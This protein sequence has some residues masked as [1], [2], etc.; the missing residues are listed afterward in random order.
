M[1]AAVDRAALGRANRRKG[2]DAERAVAKWLRANGFPHAER[3]VRTGYT[4]ND[5][6]VADPGDV[7]GT[8]GIAWQIK[9]CA[10]EQINTWLVET[11]EQRCAT[12]ADYGILVQRRRGK[13][14]PGRWWAWIDSNALARLISGR[15]GDPWV[16]KF[17]ARVELHDLT[18]LLRHCGYG[19]DVEAAS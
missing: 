4:G 11:E 9:D 18:V 14:D 15:G 3:A 5:R 16:P 12:H 8:P 1:T 7:A 10:A 2:H 13:A 17:P 19:N 6:T